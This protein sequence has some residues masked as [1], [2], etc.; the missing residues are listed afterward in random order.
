M[1]EMLEVPD[2][3]AVPVRLRG[4]AVLSRRQQATAM[5]KQRLLAP[6]RD[7]RRSIAARIT[8]AAIGMTALLVVIGLAVGTTMVGIA[9]RTDREQVLGEASLASAELTASIAD[10]RYYASR[11]AATGTESEIARAHA[12]LDRAKE[13]LA[14]TRESSV[15]T[16]ADA[17]KAME[18]LQYQVA[19]FESELSALEHSIATYGPSPIGDGLARAI[20]LSGEQLAQ[21]A[22]GVES[23]L[24]AVSQTSAAE[25]S[26]L[27][28]RL[29]IVIMA[30][31]AACIAIT[32]IGARFLARTTAGSIREITA[33]M[34]SLAKGDRSVALPG[35]ERQ[36]EIGE[37][38]RALAVFRRSAEDL[39]LLQEQAATAARQELARQESEH[40]REAAER[41]RK[42]ELLQALALRFEH[43]VGDVVGGVAAASQQ[44]EVTASSMAAAATQS[45]QLTG[46]VTRSMRETTGG[47]TAAASASDQFAMSI[48]EISRLAARSAALAEEARES[49]LSADG[50][51]AALATA[52]TEVEQIIGMIGGIA[53]RTTLLALNA[54]IEAARSG[55]AGKGFAV[56]AAEVKELAGQTSAATGKVADQI[57]AI[58]GS[59]DASVAALR[60][61]GEQ[62]HQM[63][64]SAV[65][66]AQAVDEQSMASQDLARNLAMAATGTDEIG[67]G[68]NQVSETAQS[69]G[70]AASQ[71][72]D[73]ASDLHRQAASLREQVDEFLGYVRAA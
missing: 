1:T 14:K 36:D 62:V 24:G 8:L 7:A 60:R 35:T 56:V 54:S 5:L 19:G 29:T 22:R 16:D 38:A 51:I 21:Q 20:D 71:L 23:T 15:G 43:T 17:L 4:V 63:E 3:G 49:A 26:A 30:L 31:L 25:L 52:A 13:R 70:S 59:T 50:T 32:L 34:S 11:Y 44:L 40:L 61:I 10:T 33:A 28:R 27:N 48:A 64:G 39:A 47:V 67:E 68:M 65:A 57:R 37:M 2:D 55:E 53:Q 12:T 42:A 45:A 58:Q 69:T 41:A 66:I 46:E 18:W 6:W 9:S 72:L 73:S